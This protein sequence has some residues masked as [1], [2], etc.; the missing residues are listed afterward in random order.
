MSQLLVIRTIIGTK[1]GVGGA[2]FCL[3]DN[4][5]LKYNAK[6]I[7]LLNVYI[8]INYCTILL[9]F[10]VYKIWLN[11]MFGKFGWNVSNILISRI[12]IILQFLLFFKT[13]FP[14]MPFAYFFNQWLIMNFTTDVL[15]KIA[16]HE[17]SRIRIHLCLESLMHSSMQ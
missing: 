14:K 15:S 16:T 1:N 12:S 8:I 7:Q 2:T 13:V 3:K 4:N 11:V 9:L 6:N 10:I 5:Q 17:F